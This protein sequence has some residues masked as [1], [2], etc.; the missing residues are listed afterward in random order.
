[1][2]NSGLRFVFELRGR[3]YF[4]SY[5]HEDSSRGYENLVLAANEAEAHYRLTRLAE[6]HQAQRE[7]R[8][9]GHAGQ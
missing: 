5:N 4:F 2:S 9:S 6:Y 3:H 1:M 7:L 8:A